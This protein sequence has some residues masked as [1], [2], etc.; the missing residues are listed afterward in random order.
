MT[1]VL[2]QTGLRTGWEWLSQRLSLPH[3]PPQRHSGDPKSL[4]DLSHAVVLVRIHP[5]GQ[6]SLTLAQCLGPAANSSPCSGC[7]E[8]CL[9]SLFD[10]FPLK[11]C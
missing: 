4:T 5:P 7:L 8:S 11:L 6:L 2:K 1:Q 10:Q 3:I 9:G